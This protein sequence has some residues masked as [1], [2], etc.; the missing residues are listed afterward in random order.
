VER[1]KIGGSGSGVRCER[2]G[3][4][5]ARPRA[6]GRG[7]RPVSGATHIRVSGGDGEREGGRE[8]ASG[9]VGP[10][11]GPHPSVKQGARERDWKV[12]PV[13]N[14]IKFKIVQNVRT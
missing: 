5:P 12:G 14:L 2:G 7:L 8:E 6:G 9:W 3:Q 10:W 4:A 13:A 11:E 1:G